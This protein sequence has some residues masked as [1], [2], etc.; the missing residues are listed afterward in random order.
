[1]SKLRILTLSVIGLILLN[2]SLIVFI[3]LH[4]PPHPPKEMH[5]YLKHEGPKQL[6][7]DQLHFDEQQI[8]AYE[9]LIDEHQELIKSL[10]KNIRA[11]KNNL[12]AELNKDNSSIKDSII[13]SISAYQS[14][15][16]LTHYN[17]FLEIKKLCKPNQINNFKLLTKDLAKYFGP[18]KK[19]LP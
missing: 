11:A 12:Y 10:D 7:I 2:I 15:I 4:Q 5:P 13:Q 8:N 16:E 17:H 3:S 14:Q 19:P 18:N 1:M 6:I 9:K